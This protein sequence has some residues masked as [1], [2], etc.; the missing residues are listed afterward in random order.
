MQ[1]PNVLK[2]YREEVYDYNL[3]FID[4]EVIMSKVKFTVTFIVKRLGHRLHLNIDTSIL[5]CSF[6]FCLS[7]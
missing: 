1:Q 5:H 6:F 2:L 7:I 4:G 3:T